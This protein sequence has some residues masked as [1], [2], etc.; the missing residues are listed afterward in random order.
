MYSRI[1]H[2]GSW[3]KQKNAKKAGEGF[4]FQNEYEASLC[5]KCL[6]PVAR[7]DACAARRHAACTSLYGHIDDAHD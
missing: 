7:W 3:Y 4:H 1:L 5:T 6:D 2:Y